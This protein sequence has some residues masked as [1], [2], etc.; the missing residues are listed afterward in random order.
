MFLSNYIFIVKVKLCHVNVCPFCHKWMYLSEKWKIYCVKIVTLHFNKH[1]MSWVSG[2]RLR[3]NRWFWVMYGDE[4]CAV[5][6][7]NYL[8]YGTNERTCT[9][10]AVL[11]QQAYPPS[12]ERVT[13]KINSIPF[14]QASWM[15]Q[16]T[17]F[18]SKSICQ[19]SS[20]LSARKINVDSFDKSN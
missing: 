5:D 2:C 11:L 14:L 20:K 6:V 7:I 8:E 12:F 16:M 9:F 3:G 13:Q 17:Y 1:W 19:T 15:L 10:F 4:T 18:E